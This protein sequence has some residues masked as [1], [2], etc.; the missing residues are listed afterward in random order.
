MRVASWNVNSI[1]VREEQ[2][3][4]W[5]T[6]HQPDV[7]CIQ[8]SKV[9]DEAFPTDQFMRLGYA[10]AMWGQKTYNGVALLSRLPLE[11]LTFGLQ[12]TPK[13]G[14]P[15]DNER[16][17]I[18]ARAGGLWVMSA[19]V[20]NGKAVGSAAF[21]YKLDWLARLR[22]TLD[23]LA[24]AAAPVVLCGD[25]NI[26]AD[27]R[28]V[29]DPERFAGQLHFHPDEHAALQ[30]VLAHGLVD[31]FRLH[32]DES[33]RYSWWD[34][35][36]GPRPHSRGLRIDYAFISRSLAAQCHSAEIDQATRW[37][38]RPSDHAPVIVDIDL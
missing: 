33:E 4:Q 10:V 9:T 8:E 27:G 23:T 6:Q 7:L 18:A 25:F 12:H 21:G 3:A 32:H 28:D 31:S 14:A 24:P 34:Y 26:A 11:Q 35:R 17:F 36:D 22:R 20:P 37:E 29:H 5:L 16:R 13:D 2:V 38:E 19:Y 1:R 15:A 30:G